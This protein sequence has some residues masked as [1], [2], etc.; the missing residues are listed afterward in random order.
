MPEQQSALRHQRTGT[1]ISK[2]RELTAREI[3]LGISFWPIG[4]PEIVSSNYRGHWDDPA[5]QEAHTLWTC[6]KGADIGATA[7]TRGDYFMIGGVYAAAVQFYR[8]R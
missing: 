4:V 5:V 6:S 3:E 1:E 8:E 2:L 7:F